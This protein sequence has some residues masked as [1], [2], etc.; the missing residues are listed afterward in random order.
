MVSVRTVDIQVD[1]GHALSIETLFVTEIRDELRDFEDR[2]VIR[3][4]RNYP[5]S[6]VSCSLVDIIRTM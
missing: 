5:L 6:G 1:H 2:S 3:I 4:S